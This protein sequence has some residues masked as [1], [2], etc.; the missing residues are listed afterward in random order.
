MLCARCTRFAARRRSNFGMVVP[1][2]LKWILN[3]NMLSVAEFEPV[4]C[5][6]GEAATERASIT[7]A[8]REVEENIGVERCSEMFVCS[9]FDLV[10]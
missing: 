7:A 4:E 10:T 5:G 8:R 2:R 3:G 1:E 9:K 6:T